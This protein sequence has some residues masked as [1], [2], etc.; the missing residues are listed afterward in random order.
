MVVR[1]WVAAGRTG[2]LWEEIHVL[3]DDRGW[4]VRHIAQVHQPDRRCDSEQHADQVA[5]QLRA[6][7]DWIER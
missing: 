5:A 7:G 3:Y 1:R 6:G 2:H 4:V